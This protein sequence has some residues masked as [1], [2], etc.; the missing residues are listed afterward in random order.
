MHVL[1]TGGAGFIGSH[2]SDSLIERGDRVCVLD[3][4]ST[5]SMS[6]IGHL[7]GRPGFSH[8]I[9][10]A[11]DAPLVGELVDRADWVVHLAAAVGVKMIVERPVH[12]ITTNISCPTSTPTL[13]E[14]NAS[15]S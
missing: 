13:N 7:V 10:S 3:D 12:T 14:S 5:G 15:G 8:H 2:L 11:M 6:N 4:L 1:I 9:G